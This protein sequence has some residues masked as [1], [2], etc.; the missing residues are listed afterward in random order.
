M[1]QSRENALKELEK[2]QSKQVELERDII[3]ARNGY[4]LQ[5]AAVRAHQKRFNSVDMPRLIEVRFCQ[6]I[7]E[8]KT[9]YA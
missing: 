2:L 4:L 8:F 6:K 1:F 5:L 3:D 7:V 9:S